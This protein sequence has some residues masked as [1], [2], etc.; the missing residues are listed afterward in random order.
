MRGD[1]HKARNKLIAAIRG[2]G[3]KL[4][5]WLDRH[6]LDRDSRVAMIM[7]LIA[8][9]GATTGFFASYGETHG[10]G[11]QRRLQE[12]EHF[13]LLRRQSYLGLYGE[14][15]RWADEYA[16]HNAHGYAF[17]N[18]TRSSGAR[19]PNDDVDD[20]AAQ[21]EF[22]VARMIKPV[23]DFLNPGLRSD[24]TLAPALAERVERDLRE[25]GIRNHCEPS[26]SADAAPIE[27]G[28]LQGAAD[29][30]LANSYLNPLIK[31]VRSIH[32]RSESDAWSVVVFVF[33]LVLFSLTEIVTVVVLRWILDVTAFSTFFYAVIIAVHGDAAL[34]VLYVVMFVCVALVGVAMWLL[35]PSHGLQPAPTEVAPNRPKAREH[36]DVVADAGSHLG[37]HG[38]EHLRGNPIAKWIVM[39]IAVVA[40]ASALGEYRHAF[41]KIRSDETATT[42][43]LEQLD[44]LRNERLHQEFA[45]QVVR[46]MVA[47]REVRLRAAVAHSM[48]DTGPAANRQLWLRQANHWSYVMSVLDPAAHSGAERNASAEA[49][50]FHEAVFGDNG[51][52]RDGFFP[53]AYV[54]RSTIAPAAAQLATWDAHDELIDRWERK[55]QLL[56]GAVTLFGIAFYLLGQ[57]LGMGSARG[58]LILTGFGVVVFAFGCGLGFES[59][60]VGLPIAGDMVDVPFPCLSDEE[61]TMVV[62]GLETV[63]GDTRE[64]VAARCYAR[65]EVLARLPNGADQQTLNAYTEASRLRPGFML[66]DYGAARAIARIGTP[67]KATPYV[68]V[69]ERDVLPIA[70]AFDARL[71]SELEARDTTIPVGLLEGSVLHSYLASL[72]QSDPLALRSVIDATRAA[73]RAEPHDPILRYRLAVELLAADDPAAKQAY[74]AAMTAPSTDSKNEA[75]AAAISDLEV[76]RA[77]CPNIAWLRTKAACGKLGAAADRYKSSIVGATWSTGRRHDRSARARDLKASVSPGGIAWRIPSSSNASPAVGDLVMVAYRFDPKRKSWYVLPEM[78]YIVAAP[79]TSGSE[80]AHRWISGYRSRLAVSRYSDCMQLNEKYRVELYFNGYRIG[81]ADLNLGTSQERFR[82]VAL[83][84]VGVTMCYPDEWNANAGT[85]GRPEAGYGAR[86]GNRGAYAYAFIARRGIGK[87]ELSE[88]RRRAV[89]NF[90]T[91]TLSGI[92]FRNTPDIFRTQQQR[93]AA[94]IPDWDTPHVE[95][96]SPSATVLVKA[97]TSVDGLVHVGL[98]WQR[99][100]TAD[101]LSCRVLASMTTVDDAGMAGPSVSPPAAATRSLSKF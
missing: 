11:C 44:L 84:D 15:A 12:A 100:K 79:T 91:L 53:S 86:N 22:S 96:V 41:N 81:R 93:C 89:A 27:N 64:H 5:A 94:Y 69:V 90:V 73:V 18:V 50:R 19:D 17:L 55:G 68:S 33:A 29:P 20:A 101:A 25:V 82:G 1:F 71:Q 95:Y 45:Y 3:Q 97:W 99:A 78:T 88:Q 49:L 31:E 62:K 6:D 63:N 77:A 58:G 76:L 23:K 47:L 65:A 72:D 39:V 52:Y 87:A 10:S 37:A 83:R 7:A 14:Y 28:T 60:R 61:R 43:A 70:L 56:L 35:T 67:Q 66:A 8:T 98:V 16:L 48:Y 42:A 30:Q 13:E 34:K 54:I 4:K 36:M 57:A 21:M 32:R 85:D 2:R 9:F 51:P 74:R 75:G 40:F 26:S 59:W 46:K 24:L 92:H 80:G 38:R